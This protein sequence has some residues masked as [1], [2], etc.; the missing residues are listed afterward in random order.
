MLQTCIQEKL[1]LNVGRDT[2]IQTSFSWFPQSFQTNDT[3]VAGLCH[4]CF[5]PNP[6]QFIIHPIACSL[7]YNMRQNIQYWN[8]KTNNITLLSFVSLFLLKETNIHTISVLIYHGMHNVSVRSVPPRCRHCSYRSCRCASFST[9]YFGAYC[10]TSMSNPPPL[11]P[12]ECFDRT[13]M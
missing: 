12:W 7:W 1:G 6:F 10:T 9:V 2:A 8:E 5:L 4:D 3:L 13:V 11:K